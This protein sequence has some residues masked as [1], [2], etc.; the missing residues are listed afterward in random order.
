MKILFITNASG[1]DYLSDCLFHGFVDCGYDVVDS[2]YLWYLSQ[3]LN[4]NDKLK[5][6]GRGFTIAGNLP[7]RSKIDRTNIK[8]RILSHE[9]DR[10]VYGSITRCSDYLQEVSSIYT[11]NEVIICNGE[12]DTNFNMELTKAGLCFKRELIT[13]QL[14]PI[15]FAIPESKI[16]NEIKEKTQVLSNI[17]PGT[18]LQRNYSFID[19]NLYYDEYSKSMFGLTKKK[20]GWDCLRHY[21]IIASKCLPYFENYQM[22]PKFTMMNWP[23]ELQ[24]ESNSMYETKNFSQYSIVLE[25]FSKYC[26]KHLTTKALA[27]YVLSKG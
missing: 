12:D 25:E 16:R 23:T 9:F 13:S 11:K 21:E 18:A 1:I 4:I 20:A 10:I 17:I 14:Y 6:Y 5:L 15:S 27:N 3:P 22:C 24:R 19:E 7:D 26:F 2:K 8:E